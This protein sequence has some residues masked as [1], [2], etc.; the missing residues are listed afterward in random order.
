VQ[1]P[2]N[3]DYFHEVDLLKPG[4]ADRTLLQPLYV[5]RL[6]GGTVDEVDDP[7]GSMGIARWLFLY[8]NKIEHYWNY[9]ST[10][11]LLLSSPT[12]ELIFFRGVGIPPT[13][14][15]YWSKLK[16][17]LSFILSLI[18]S[19]DGDWWAAVLRKKP[20]IVVIIVRIWYSSRIIYIYH[21]LKIDRSSFLWS[22]LVVFFFSELYV[23]Y[24]HIYVNR[25]RTGL[26]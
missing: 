11:L 16:L 17:V 23:G 13:S 12:D 8:S 15:Y 25:Q 4:L 2:L 18:C 19:W 6:S 14:Y 10:L 5:R 22:K 7:W 9:W 21:P 3:G 1:E 26:N 24:L 20:T